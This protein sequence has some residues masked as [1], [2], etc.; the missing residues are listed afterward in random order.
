M[1]YSFGTS[2]KYQ[3]IG[4]FKLGDVFFTD[5]EPSSAYKII[6]DSTETNFPYILLCLDNATSI[7]SFDELPTL[8]DI[9]DNIGKVKFTV[10]NENLIL[11]IR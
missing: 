2:I 6:Y 9:E 3:A 8:E 10:P 1:N 5:D 11:V 4:D 7:Q